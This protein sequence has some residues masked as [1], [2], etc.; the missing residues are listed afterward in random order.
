MA[1]DEKILAM[2]FARNEQAVREMDMQYG[3][4]CHKLAYNILNDLRD[5]EECVNDAYFGVWNA[6]PPERPMRL[7]AYLCKIVRN[8]ALK[9]LSQ[10]TA[11]KR[12]AHTVAFEELADCLSQGDA[13]SEAVDAKETA[14]LLSEFL[15]T[16]PKENRVIFMRRYWFCDPYKD[17]AARVG[18]SE[19]NVSVRLARVRKQLKTY[20]REKEDLK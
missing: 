17:I 5:A 11:A 4:I 19:K 9:R 10:N 8:L 2:L 13:V 14:R 6:V 15:D 16:L 7:V 12:S 20:L 3:R 1:E 18:L